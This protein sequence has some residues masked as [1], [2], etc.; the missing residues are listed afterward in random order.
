MTMSAQHS[1]TAA[2]C[3][4]HGVNRLTVV[5][6]RIAKIVLVGCLLVAASFAGPLGTRV[7][8][9]TQQTTSI[10][11][12]P[13]ATTTASPIGTVMLTPTASPTATAT[14][15][16]T[17]PSPTVTAAG[18][19]TI[20][21]TI[22][23]LPTHLTAGGPA[24]EFT[25]ILSNHTASIA[26]DVAPVF[27]IVGG[28]CHCMNG[29]LQRLDVTTGVW[30]DVVMPEGDGY[31]PLVV[32]ADGIDLAPGATAT[33]HL[34]LTVSSNNVAEPALSILYA[35]ALP[36]HSL[37]GQTSEQNQ[38]DSSYTPPPASGSGSG[39]APMSAY[40]STIVSLAK[41]N[42]GK[43]ACSTNSL[44]GTG[45]ETSCTGNGGYPELW[46]ADFVK[47]VWAN[48]GVDTA[49]LT[50][51]AGSFGLYGQQKGT[52]SNTPA[53]GDAVVFNYNSNGYADHVALVTQV[54]ADGTIDSIG[55]DENGQLGNW[56]ATSHVQWDT[57]YKGNLGGQAISGYIAPVGLASMPTNTP[58]PTATK[59]STPRPTATSTP[60]PTATRTSAPR[61][62]ATRTS[63]PTP[64]STPTKTP[65]P[66][67]TPVLPAPGTWTFCATEGGTCSFSGTQAVAFGADGHFAYG[68]Y[69]GGV[70]CNTGF[71]DPAPGASKACY[72][73]TTLTPPAPGA[74]TPCASEG[75]T[76]SFSGTQAVA[77]GANGHFAYGVYTGSALC[78]TGF[79]DPAPGTTKACYTSTTL[80]PPAPG[81]WI[82]CANEGGTCSFSGTQAVAFGASGHFA[83]GV[84][85]NGVACNTGFGDPAPGASKSCYTS[86]TLTPPAPGAW[87]PCASEGGTCSFSGTQAVAFGA[88][89]HFAYG[90][91]TGSALCNTGFGDPAPGT[92]KACYTSTTLTPPAPGA[93][94]PC[95]NEG[96]TCSFSGT[97]A[98]AF[99]A[100]GHFAYGVYTNGVACNTGFGDP[101]PGTSKSCY[102]STTLPPPTLT[103]TAS[104]TQSA[105]AINS[106]GEAA[107]NF[108]ADTDVT[109][110]TTIYHT[111]NTI[112]TSGVTNPAPQSVYQ[113]ERSGSDF[114]YTI[115]GLMP[116]ATYL[117]RLHFAEFA[118]SG[119]GIRLFNVKINGQQVLTNFDIYATAGGQNKA[120][121]EPFLAT[122]DSSGA[123]T[124][125]YI[126]VAGG[127]KSSGIEIVSAPPLAI[128]SG[129][130][131]VGTFVGDT[132][133]TGGT[134]IYSTTNAIDT[135]GVT[136]PAPQ[137]VYQT[138]RS[139]SSFT[140][141]IP[142]F[143][144]GA[145][146]TLRLHFA[147]WTFSSPGVRLFNVTI[148][149]QQALTNFDI[150]ATAGGQNKAVVEQFTTTANSSGQIVITYTNV[151]GGAKSSGIEILPAS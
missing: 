6:T 70:A 115:P 62:T 144:L 104:P 49:G 95:A 12:T 133:V 36:S 110:G 39:I 147:E 88:N 79:G 1:T 103:P 138:E 107:G 106:G 33:V 71:G 40:A 69:T 22:V 92:T 128:N 67:V 14:L 80:T 83:Y 41:D 27:Q 4:V 137:A 64:T 135:S 125:E 52:W 17:A 2:R 122:A 38:I 31:N 59:T 94:I 68:V 10:T 18:P 121:V 101:A 93:W 43:H 139:G 85:T 50:A 7:A 25:A 84:Y 111:S 19:E 28:A 82:P 9:A 21:A 44:G 75:G 56:A 116:N 46:C 74:W 51:A 47:W 90:V 129:G 66:T 11:T 8:H 100:S 109:G 113:T 73:S 34:R 143:K 123:I 77:F 117:V 99:G 29:S 26:R 105:L 149:G 140:Y 76:C 45:F 87:T 60:R 42:L 23:G 102:T 37:V 112:D 142:G 61:P 32:A 145:P 91:Y 3:S 5:A 78:N 30:H 148:N 114:I 58:R 130:G 119:P 126:N 65:S 98:V 54:N 15:A 132:D 24:V 127:A 72:T 146:Y 63:T 151:S 124:I 134:T 150:Y 108:V 57:G 97:Q 53:V 20:T 81:A 13:V 86:T 55:G 16:A 118:F 35:V 48:S 89:G 96:G 141:T 120:V 131:V 136:N